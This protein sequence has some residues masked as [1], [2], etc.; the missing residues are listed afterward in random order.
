MKK[1]S[2]WPTLIAVP[3]VLIIGAWALATIRLQTELLP[4]LPQQLDSVR[5]MSLFQAA[6]TSA[7]DVTVVFE[8][9]ANVEE[10]NR[11]LRALP[12]V[13]ATTTLGGRQLEP[14]VKSLAWI[15]ANLPPEKFAEFQTL[16]AADRLDDRLQSARD[17]LAGAVNFSAAAML[18]FDPLG[19]LSW[20]QEHAGLPP[21]D[22]A[23][24]SAIVVHA[25]HELRTFEDCQRFVDAVR[26]VTGTTGLITGRAAFVSETSKQMR[27]DMFLMVGV[28]TVLVALAFWLFYRSLGA[29][30][31]ILALQALALLC[32]VVAARLLFGELNVLSIGF[33]SILLGVGMDYCILVYHFHATGAAEQN[34]QHWRMLRGAIWLSALTTAA[35]FGVL[36]FAS[37]PGL[38]QLAVLIG[39]GLL[40]TAFFATV[41]EP[42]VL[43][44]TKPV[45][46]SWLLTSSDGFAAFISRYRRGIMVMLILSL[47]VTAGLFPVL[48]RYKFY[49]ADLKRLRPAASE[50]YRGLDVLL[51]T[52]QSREIFEVIVPGQTWDEL[53]ANAAAAAAAAGAPKP[54]LVPQDDFLER[55]RTSWQ[56]GKI[57]LVASALER[58]G[59]DESWGRATTLLLQ[60]LDKWPADAEAKLFVSNVVKLPGDEKLALLRLPS[61]ASAWNAV[62][63]AVPAALP[64]NWSLLTSDLGLSA[65]ADFRKLSVWILLAVVGLCWLAHRS[66]RLVALNMVGLLI[67][68]LGLLM[69]LFVTRQSMTLMSLLS[70]PLLVGM[71]IDISLHL[72]LAMEENKGDI[73]GT[74]RHMAGPVLLTGLTSM[75]GFGAPMATQQPVLQNF[76]MVMDLGI[77]AAV[78]TGLVLLPVFH[79]AAHLRPH[80]SATLYRAFWF[81]LAAAYVRIV[82]ACAARATGRFLGGL[83]RVT[84]PHRCRVARANLALT[85][86]KTDARTLFANFGQTMADYFVLGNRTGE[87]ARQLI[88]EHVGDKPL[89]AVV[90]EGRGALLVT[91]HLGLFELGSLLMPEIGQ[92]AVIVTAPEPSEELGRWRAQFRARWGAE[93]FEVA[94]D[95][96]SFV[97]IT[98]RLAK[99][100]CVAMLIDR[101][102]GDNAVPVEFPCGKVPFSTGPVWLSLLSGA[103]IVPVTVTARAAGGYRVEAHAPIRPQWLPEGRDETVRHYTREVGALFRKVICEHPEQWYQFVDLSA[104]R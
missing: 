10:L 101:P 83:Y 28:A 5:G 1:P 42:L 64:A 4:L 93:T 59:F 44:R 38:Q 85:G 54:M 6:F 104:S 87:A 24:I 58:A 7:Q 94:T 26:S 88:A 23:G 20:L 68:V 39:T 15:I 12:E 16:F 47:V 14:M 61:S 40:A 46:P 30:L 90:A 79:S 33:A 18:Q 74:F 63:T 56:P 100:Q 45:A 99:G 62:K 73:R 97:E 32:G 77:F 53:R 95:N 49:D 2:V 9:P 31:W 96:F 48:R 103:P 86:A 92:G 65:R 55:N 21:Q 41:T 75:I 43:G 29:L 36:Y 3:L 50:A 76:G 69:L 89:R 82:G 11:Q 19:L 60:E 51:K 13:E 81:D 8:S 91:A 71:I 22:A 35:S 70:V 98:R 25:R 84:H 57:V 78:V 80:Y 102:Y 37:F 66:V 52:Q 27:R 34:G 72:V 67:S 17:E